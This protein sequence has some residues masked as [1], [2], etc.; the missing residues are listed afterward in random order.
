MSFQQFFGLCA[1]SI[2]SLNT[3]DAKPN[4]GKN[5]QANNFRPEANRATIGLGVGVS[6]PSEALDTFIL[7]VRINPNFTLEPMINLMQMS[8]SETTTLIDATDPTITTSTTSN[9]DLSTRGGGLA[10]RYRVGRHGNTDLNAIAGVGYASYT[11]ENTVEGVQGKT[12]TAGTSTVANLGLGMENFFAPRWSAG[13]DLTTP[14]YQ[15]T[16]GTATSTDSLSTSMAIAPSFKIMLA[17]Y[18]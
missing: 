8:S 10:M 13:F 6:V 3:A 17:H 15:S 9:T 12:T 2:L 14:I 11:S 5:A 1:L 7:R 18:F 16:T 4:N